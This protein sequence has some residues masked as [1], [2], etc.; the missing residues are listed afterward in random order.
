MG[1]TGLILWEGWYQWEGV[2]GGERECANIVYTCMQME[3]WYLLKLLQEW[4]DEGIKAHDG[5]VEFQ[6]DIL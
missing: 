4:D 2:G 5:G 1:G 6:Y 3:K